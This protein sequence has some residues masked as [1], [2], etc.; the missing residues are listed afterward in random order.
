MGKKSNR[1]EK[2]EE[3][4]YAWHVDLVGLNGTLLVIAPDAERAA[5][6]ARKVAR[7]RFAVHYGSADIRKLSRLGEIDAEVV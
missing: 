7:K 1:I 5:G 6:G 4:R 2:A 3:Q